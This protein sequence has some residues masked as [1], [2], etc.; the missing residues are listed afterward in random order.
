[1]RLQAC[2]ELLKRYKCC[3]KVDLPKDT[4]PDAIAV[5]ISVNTTWHQKKAARILLD[6]ALGKNL[7]DSL[8]EDGAVVKDRNDRLV[9]KW[10]KSV[11]KRDGRCVKCGELNG[12]QAHHISE[13]ADDPVNRVNVNNGV[14]LCKDCHAKEHPELR[15][16]ILA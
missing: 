6:Y 15:N 14:T 4:V 12:L 9:R 11:V 10:R 2:Q 16:L 13:W 7:V 3:K 8:I 1:M 5:I